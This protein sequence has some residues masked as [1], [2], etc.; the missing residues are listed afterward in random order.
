MK[1]RATYFIIGCLIMVPFAAS[2]QAGPEG[3]SAEDLRRQLDDLRVQMAAQ[4]K[5]M[6]ALRARLDEMDRQK[7]TAVASPLASAGVDQ[8]AVPPSVP[9]QQVGEATTKY[10]TFN[11]DGE[12]APR[13]DNAPLDPRFPGFFR[14]P[15]TQTL[16]ENW[17]IF[18]DR[19]HLRWEAGG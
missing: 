2:A 3:Q 12:A 15:G 14:L 9:T 18:Q 7:T 10:Q 19:F 11:L 17:R 5:Q 4:M 8:P 16:S 1:R 6:S 13:I